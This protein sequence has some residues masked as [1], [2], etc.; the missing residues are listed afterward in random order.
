MDFDVTAALALLVSTISVGLSVWAIV[1]QREH[2]R[3]SVRPLCEVTPSDYRNKIKL[4]LKNNGIGPLIV[5]KFT[6]S[7]G[8]QE[9]NGVADLVPP[10]PHNRAWDDFEYIPPGRSLPPG[11]EIVL[12]ELTERAGDPS[13]VEA[14][15]IARSALSKMTIRIDFTDVYGK[16]VASFEKALAWYG[17][18]E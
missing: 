15:D 18:H 14:R 1:S 8:S 5:K 16:N 6:V 13:F 3:L 10:L 2:N 4:V 12:L 11:E 7:D 17:R 9:S